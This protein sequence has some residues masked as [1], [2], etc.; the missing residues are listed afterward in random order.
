MIDWLEQFELEHPQRL[1]A[2]LLVPVLFYFS[3]ASIAGLPQWRRVTSAICRALL[4][5]TVIVAWSGIRHRGPTDEIYT[6][7]V[8]DRSASVDIAELPPP[9]DTARSGRLEFG[10]RPRIVRQQGGGAE[11][12]V[13]PSASD[14]G[15]GVLL[16]AG[17]FPAGYVPNIV[18]QTDGNET[19]GDLFAAA[20]AADV[21]IHA[22]RLPPSPEPEVCL[23]EVNVLPE[24]SGG[25]LNVEI[26]VTS[27]RAGDGQLFWSGGHVHI[28]EDRAGLN[29]GHGPSTQWPEQQKKIRV[30]KG[31]NRF[32][33]VVALPGRTNWAVCRAALEGFEDTIL[34]NNARLAAVAFAR[35]PSVLY[36]SDSGPQ[37]ARN[38][39]EAEVSDNTG[40]PEGSGELKGIECLV[41]QS[42]GS[43]LSAKNIAVIKEY[44]QSGGGLIVKGGSE[45]FGYES[46]HNSELEELMPVRGSK[47]LVAGRSMLAMLLVIDKSRSMLD[48]NRLGLAKDAA[49][50]TV[51]LELLTAEDK[52]GILAFGSTSEWISPIVPCEDKSELK[53][54][55]DGLK[56]EGQTNMFP[57]L[58]RAYLALSEAHADRRHVILLTDGVPS[59]GDFGEIARRMVD[60]GITVSTVSIGAG[61]DQSI[62]KDISRIASGRHI[63][64][65]A[66]EE[67][68]SKLVAEARSAAGSKR[69]QYAV[70]V[71][72]QLP[73]LDVSTAP[74]L[75]D[76]A[77]TSP[78]PNA[79]LLLLAGPGDPLLAWRQY[80]AGKVA[81]Y[82]SGRGQE[83][84]PPKWNGET[85]FWSRIVNLV[86]R[87]PR[88]PKYSLA[89]TRHQSTC[90]VELDV[91]ADDGSF[92]NERIV[93]LGVHRIV[94]TS[95]G[96]VDL[97]KSLLSH[98]LQQVAAGRY[99]HEFELGQYGTYLIDVHWK[100]EF[101]DQRRLRGSI[102]Y[103]FPDEYLLKSTNETLLRNV[104]AVSGGSYDA[105]A[106]EMGEAADRTIERVTAV[107]RYFILVGMILFVVDVALRRA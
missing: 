70:S 5:G 106:A 23:T 87:Q 105:G 81:A 55:I 43:G 90:R 83:S 98:Q 12:A 33:V 36:C 10:R 65:E 15:E 69:E 30:N 74:P 67:L 103:D 56:A 84:A 52:L 3:F 107:W 16:A 26:V 35:P 59:P 19:D 72:R 102:S 60:A 89:I 27:N 37:V 1:Y 11:N 9:T 6:I 91:V 62:L 20:Q 39:F 80:G 53:R 82:T 92:L 48:D 76:Y 2:L 49:K 41:L 54:R 77:L 32:Q 96:V 94:R 104:A 34:E 18:L 79:E 99:A 14:P 63:H 75:E 71:Y 50:R 31:E 101:A 95:D 38:G 97:E 7:F 42:P 86:R 68:T 73:D 61:A 45:T 8:A 51:D 88:P 78:K 4:I 46:F 58:Q 17:S 93:Q 24:S 44:V 21:P 28:R 22:Q 47:E 29:P 64:C 85:K 25:V 100:D 13:D 57:A 40:Y 66:A